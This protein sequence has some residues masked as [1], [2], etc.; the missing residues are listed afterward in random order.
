MSLHQEENKKALPDKA[1]PP[2]VSP[3]PLY[4]K[5]AGLALVLAGFA[6][7]WLYG[8][9]GKSPDWGWQPVW[10]VLLSFWGINLFILFSAISCFSYVELYYRL[11][12]PPLSG[13]LKWLGAFVVL[14]LVVPLASWTLIDLSGRSPVQQNPD[15]APGWGVW[16]AL[17]GLALHVAGL[18]LQINHIRRALNVTH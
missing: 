2:V 9:L 5:L 18:R 10:G 15:A 8:R 11:E 13:L 14:I 3:L 12:R 16:L 17:A 1:T 6:G 7:P 4:L